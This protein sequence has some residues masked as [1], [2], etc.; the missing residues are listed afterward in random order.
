MCVIERTN[1]NIT[2]RLTNARWNRLME[3]E[4]AY[5]MARTVLRAK[6]ECENA[7]SMSVAEA[8]DF[9]DNL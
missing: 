6:Q 8:I 7:T 3:L 4:E 9:V 5:R 2:V 1:R